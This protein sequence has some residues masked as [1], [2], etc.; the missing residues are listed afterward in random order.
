M[1]AL[2]TVAGIAAIASAG[3]KKLK[4][5]GPAIAALGLAGASAAKSLTQ[6]GAAVPEL[7]TAPSMEDLNLQAAQKASLAA[8]RA[9]ALAGGTGTH[10]GTL[11]TGPGGLTTPATTAPKTLLGL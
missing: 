8:T 11:L 1:A 9:R 2:S 10:G 4:Q 7:P 5:N 3:F 6:K